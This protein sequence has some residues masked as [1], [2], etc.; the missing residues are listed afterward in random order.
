MRTPF[1]LLLV[2]CSLASLPA[3]AEL[4]PPA[5]PEIPVSAPVIAAA[6]LEQSPVVAD[7][8]GNVALV[9]WHDDRSGETLTY[10][11]RIGPGGAV[12]D[13]LGIRIGHGI[14]KLVLWTGEEFL[15]LLQL[16]IL[17]ELVYIDIDGEIVER[18]PLDVEEP[19]V[20]TLEAAELNHLLFLDEDRASDDSSFLRGVIVTLFPT[21][22][23]SE[24][25]DLPP[26]PAGLVDTHWLGAS[27]DTDFLV[28]RYQRRVSGGTGDRIVADRINSDGAIVSS[29]NTGLTGSL[30]LQDVFAGK[31]GGYMLVRHL[32]PNTSEIQ[33][34][35]LTPAGLYTGE[36]DTLGPPGPPPFSEIRL[37]R[38]GSHYLFAWRAPMPSLG[39]T[40]TFLTTVTTEGQFGSANL[41]GDWRGTVTGIALAA[42]GSH[43]LVFEGVRHQF[44]SSWFDVM[45]TLVSDTFATVVQVLVAQSATLQSEVRVA[46]SD[47]GYI[48]GWGENGPDRLARA[49]VRRFSLLGAPLDP[50]PREIYSFEQD[51]ST[52]RLPR[53]RVAANAGFYVVTWLTPDGLFARRIPADGGDWLDSEPIQVAPAAT[54]FDVTANETHALIVWTSECSQGLLCVMSRRLAMSGSPDLGSAQIVSGRSFNHDVTA[55]TNGSDFLVAWIEGRRDCV[56]TCGIDPHSVLGARVSSS[57]ALLDSVPLPLEERRTFVEKPVIAWDGENYVV[58]WSAFAN[59]WSVRGVRV[60]PQGAIFEKEPNGNGTA[61]D[62][63][64]AA[65]PAQPVLARLFDELVL[66]TPRLERVNQY[67]QIVWSVVTFP[68]RTPLATVR[69]LPRQEA[70]RHESEQFGTVHA[71][72]SP[73]GLL[74]LG[75]DRVAEGIYAGVPRAFVTRFGTLQI[76]RRRAVSH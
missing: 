47:P 26:A 11:A 34:F 17:H 19:Y 45:S 49:F 15:V 43:R 27:D 66:L 13:P 31:P 8:N 38:E 32:R 2:V 56:P 64:I 76:G 6:P 18:V 35:R 57:G 58:L 37:I 7:S 22:P 1:F 61:V 46:A 25:I 63:G 60:T 20:A 10:A 73:K 68:A 14:P 53:V 44:S 71:A 33:S 72:T 75:Y 54:H 69:T 24:P 51:T 12:L 65:K 9:V 74:Y 55:S 41:V 30:D 48:V 16:P 67:T 52:L 3:T 42:E 39:I 70:F 23:V 59:G 50:A 4:P 21:G 5:I 40:R 62:E 36:T 28:L 29:T